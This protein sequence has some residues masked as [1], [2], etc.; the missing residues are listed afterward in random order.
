VTVSPTLV[1]LAAGLGRRFGGV[2]QLAPVGPQG[3]AILDYSVSDARAAGF[4]RIVLVVR[5]EIED[6]VAAHISRWPAD[7][8]VSLVAQDR[9]V[10]S[11]AAATTGRT[12]PL[13]TAHAV[14]VAVSDIDGPFAVI[15]ADDLYGAAAFATIA[16]HLATHSGGALV[17]YGAANTILGSAPVKRALCTVDERHHLT[18]IEEGTIS[19]GED[20]RLAWE[21]SLRRQALTGEEAVSMNF[22]GFP[23]S[24]AEAM[25]AA[26]ES[27][28]T[29][30]RAAG[31]EEVLLP[32]VVRSLMDSGTPFTALPSAER[33]LGI[34][35]P[36]DLATLHSLI[37]HPAW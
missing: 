25:V 6:A 21:N 30:G 18:A 2:K 20:G 17:V 31:D 23:A 7:L 29:E 3:E 12:V 9:H 5:S 16:H 36:D 37:C 34:T 27:F 24:A 4:S 13:G 1:V 35:H 10:L 32:D 15:N 28:V 11:V 22:W 26:S 19:V 8:A 33:C 14:A